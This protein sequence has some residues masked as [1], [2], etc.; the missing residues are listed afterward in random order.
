MTPEE[1][2][3]AYKLSARPYL[4]TPG[5]VG[6]WS[7]FLAMKSWRYVLEI[8]SNCNLKCALCH[9]GN[10]QGFD[11]HPGI[12]DM[13]LFER[14]LDKIQKENPSATVCAYVNSEPFLH[15]KL[16]ECIRS[17]KKRGLRC[18]IASNLNIMKNLAEVFAAQ[19][20]MFTVSVSGFTQAMY[21]KA[22]RGG[23]IEVVKANIKEVAEEYKRG[24]YQFYCGVSYHLYND[25]QGD[26]LA[27][28]R[29]YAEG[30]GL[31]F[32]TSFARA[33]TMEHAVLSCRHVEK[34]K[35]GKVEP[36]EVKNGLD[37][38]KILPAAN[39][40]YLKHLE[41]VRMHPSKA[42]EF[43]SQWP[44]APVC[45]IADVFTEIRHDGRVQLCA[46]TDD[47]RLTLGNYLEMTQD[48]I[49]EA[50]IGHPFC[51]DCLKYRLNLYFHIVNG[52]NW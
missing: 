45:K 14:I 49:S 44:V 50:R 32:F 13:D 37:L 33:I 26:E 2:E 48:Q 43:Y 22:H 16:A 29:A 31:K 47:M 15:P 27:Q 46:W 25:N 19:P 30:L 10:R 34:E 12:M 35:T 23:D 17:I 52:P 8:N 5:S 21:E 1:L 24:G 9:A 42:Q 20:D 4:E 36:F 11:Y 7:V 51:R 40:E 41:R 38:N 3:A 6:D 28:M 18:E 39:P